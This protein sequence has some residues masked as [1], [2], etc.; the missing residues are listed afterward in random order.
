MGARVVRLLAAAVSGTAV[1]AVAGNEAA[2]GLAAGL[3]AVVAA[4]VAAAAGLA[5]A[6]TETALAGA[7]ALV[8]PLD[9]T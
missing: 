1:A 4:A 2:A 9:E 5:A 3:A 7:G 8:L 6:L